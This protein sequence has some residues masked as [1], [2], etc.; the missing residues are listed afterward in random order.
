MSA[1]NHCTNWK[2]VFL[3]VDTLVQLDVRT[4]VQLDVEN[5]AMVISK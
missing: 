2:Y 4:L 1:S 3:Q 5:L